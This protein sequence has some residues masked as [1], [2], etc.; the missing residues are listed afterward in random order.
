M[1]K[2][3]LLLI[4]LTSINSFSQKGIFKKGTITPTTYNESLKYL[5]KDHAIILDVEIN[6]KVYKFLL[7]TGAPTVISSKIE[8]DFPFLKEESITDAMTN[9][10]NVKYVS[11]PLLKIGNLNFHNFT[12]MQEHLTP[13]DTMGID[14]I[15]GANIISKSAWDFDLE[16]NKIIISNKLDKKIVKNG[17]NKIK[18]KK[19][20]S[21]T[22]TLNL[23]YFNA[24]NEKGIFFD[25]GYAGL[26]YLSHNKY[27]EF[28]KLG[29][30]ANEIEGEGHLSTNAFGVDEGK[31]YKFPIDLSIDDIK[32][33][34]FISAIDN[35]TESNL[36]CKWLIYYRTI[37]YKNYLY[38]KGNS[39]KSISEDFSSIGI[40]TEII[41]N[42]IVVNFIWNNSK[43]HKLG[44]KNGDTILSVNNKD[45]TTLSTKEL[46]V[47]NDLISKE[48]KV[49]LEIN[50]KGNFIT[51]EKET[52][53]SITP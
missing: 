24:L 7:D 38:F 50:T 14:G 43:A 53:L 33:P 34:T 49:T 29:L 27:I 28:K 18:T 20:Y 46:K 35:D 41:T 6:K 12:A 48:S 37:L 2:I 13:F 21:G 16:N 39:E 3:L 4:I 5:F 25:T 11:I 19:T 36:G 31:T 45:F 51:L 22:P 26:F 9:S 17:F 23:S 47:V 40:S 8:G 30:I 52:L 15:I 10:Q 1:K 32:I 44:I 42:S